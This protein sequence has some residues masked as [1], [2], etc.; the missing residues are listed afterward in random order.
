MGI[1]RG[2]F[3][4]NGP[5]RKT[6]GAGAPMRYRWR[7]MNAGADKTAA[8]DVAI[9]GAGAAGIGAALAAR[10]L[11][12]SF[13][14]LEAMG[15]IGGRAF[16]DRAAFG[17]PWDA[18]CFILHSASEN[19]LARVAERLGLTLRKGLVR[20]ARMLKGAALLE[21]AEAEALLAY[22]EDCWA[23]IDEAA[24]AGR[25][26]ACADVLDRMHPLWPQF[27][28]R[29]AV[30]QGVD[31]EEASTLDHLRYRDTH[32]NWPVADGYGTLIARIAQGI[33][34]RL[35]TPVTA[36]DYGAN[37]LRLETPGGSIR[38]R[39]AVL[40]ASTG[41]LAAETIR[42]DPKLPDWKLRAIESVPIG[43]AD[44]I[45]FAFP[46]GAL[47]AQPNDYLHVVT[48]TR[49]TL[50]FHLRPFG[51][52]YA[53][54]YV[55]GSTAVS[56][57]DASDDDAFDFAM[58][59]LVAAFGA[60]IAAKATARRRTRWGKEPWIRGGY[61]AARPGEALARLALAEPLAER[62]YFAGEASAPEFFS[63]AHGAYLSGI[64]AAMG[65]ARA[66][67]HAMTTAPGPVALALGGAVGPTAPR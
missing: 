19:P 65:A 48:G 21:E 17:A 8:C 3:R 54:G 44:K 58:E 5:V 61:S 30:F 7:A 57:A 49:R 24:D 52:D 36:I 59:K 11:G 32:E 41:V 60:S 23:R 31:P 55:G 35:N 13:V 67:G 43:F 66:I 50:G 56:L 38:A 28:H 1:R 46:P 20:R 14:V 18:G 37:P 16:T 39:A 63:T 6:V 25:D 27:A 4:A 29:C 9:V 47:D 51:Y 12:L 40:T 26:V 34:V 45:A 33:P 22:Y 15:R 62:L 10:A 64:D 2:R 53:S 42:F